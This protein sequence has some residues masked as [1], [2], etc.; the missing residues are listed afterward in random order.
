MHRIWRVYY[1]FSSIFFSAYL[2]VE[3]LN[4]KAGIKFYDFDSKAIQGN[5]Q[6]STTY[7]YDVDY[8]SIKSD[9]PPRIVENGVVLFDPVNYKI[10][11]PVKF[12]FQITRGDTYSNYD[13]F[14]TIAIPR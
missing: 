2:T 7:S 10:A 8:P 4:G 13:F 9:I 14:Y 3:N 12:Q 6:F 11:S 5:R 1:Q